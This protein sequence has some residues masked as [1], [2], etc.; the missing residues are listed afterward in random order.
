MGYDVTMHH[1][2][3]QDQAT[4]LQIVQTWNISEKPEYRGFRCANCQQYRNQAWYH[5]VT[6]GDFKLPIHLCNESCEAQF[7]NGT[8]QIT[9]PPIEIDHASFGKGYHYSEA[10]V[11]RF[12]QIVGS[13][14]KDQ[15]PQLKAFSCDQCQQN[16]LIDPSDYQRKGWHV[17][18]KM[19]DGKTLAELHFHKEC[20][21][22]LGITD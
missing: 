10:A 8:L 18:W 11:T 7:Q 4:L 16:L 6:T 17:W 12:R 14:L 15:A 9:N 13:W 1:N 19:D 21:A 5:W 20:A 3:D 22:A 2:L